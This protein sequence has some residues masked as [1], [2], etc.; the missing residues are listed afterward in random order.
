M[1]T[2][3]LSVLVLT[4]AGVL[5]ASHAT[6]SFVADKAGQTATPS[7]LSSFGTPSQSPPAPA[8][9]SNTPAP[10]NKA[11]TSLTAGA[12]AGGANSHSPTTPAK[13][14]AG[15]SQ[16]DSTACNE[17]V[18]VIEHTRQ[19]QMEMIANAPKVSEIASDL[20][21]S[22]VKGCMAG[23]RDAIDLSIL[24]PNGRGIAGMGDVV[25]DYAKKRIQVMK[26][27]LLDKACML[28]TDITKS[29]V[30]KV[31]KQLDIYNRTVEIINNPDKVIGG[32]AI[33]Q[34][35]EAERRATGRLKD[36]SNQ[37]E[38][39]VNSKNRDWEQRSKE[40]TAQLD[41]FNKQ[42]GTYTRQYE[43]SVNN[44]T[45]QPT[46]AGQNQSIDVNTLNNQANHAG[47]L[48]EA[49]IREEQARLLKQLKEGNNNGNL[50]TGTSGT[51][52]NPQNNPITNRGFG[53]ITT[54]P[55]NPP[56][57]TGNNQTQTNAGSNN[58]GS[59]TA[60]NGFGRVQ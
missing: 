20:Q 42:A 56:A 46:Q 22:A 59:S 45:N 33:A 1:K 49:R 13:M 10:T 40:R 2:F 48:E 16:A 57:Q 5:P 36:Y 28:A 34:M 24:I 7:V 55:T 3:Q 17:I 4:M 29:T 6:T 12:T 47:A 44:S 51:T 8:T 43:T 15:A 32:W 41:D 35:N 60:P 14:T 50:G 54:A 53:S 18:E 11:T 19:S 30:D 27:E 26:D 39:E 23:I 58:N 21:N 37:L 52:N 38:S 9:S 25:I 31:Q